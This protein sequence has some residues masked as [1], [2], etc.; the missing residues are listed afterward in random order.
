MED[1]KLKNIF[2]DF[3]PDVSSDVSFMSK[4]QSNLDAV[5]M[6]YRHNAEQ[7]AKSKKA[8]AIAAA[9]GF[10]VG[11]LFSMMLPVIGKAIVDLQVSAPD[12]P[13]IDMFTRYYQEIM[14]IMIGAVVVFSSIGTYDLSLSLM[15]KR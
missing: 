14:W 3:K 15:K 1:D 2:A 5:E 8:V 12:M 9:V 13:A 7:R 4:L 6:V 10:M 11:L